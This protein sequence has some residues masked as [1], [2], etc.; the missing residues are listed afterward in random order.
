MI[1]LQVTDIQAQESMQ[2]LILRVSWRKL[3]E[4][5]DR[6]VCWV[7]SYFSLQQHHIEHSFSS[8]SLRAIRWSVIRGDRNVWQF[9][10]YVLFVILVSFGN[11]VEIL[12]HLLSSC[13][14]KN[15]QI[16][17]F[18]VN[19][20]YKIASLKHCCRGFDS[21]SVWRYRSALQYL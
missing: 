12:W 9:S 19:F 21:Q 20:K 8:C 3:H 6:W 14:N 5:V 7:T 18:T 4:K 10:W 1:N 16:H 11:R 17:Q 2:A 15:V 13:W